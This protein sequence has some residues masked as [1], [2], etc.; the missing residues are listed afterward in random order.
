[1]NI[2]WEKINLGV[3]KCHKYNDPED[4]VI[5]M[6]LTYFQIEK[7]LDIGYGLQ[8][9][10]VFIKLWIIKILPSFDDIR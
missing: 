4:M 8:Y 3:L 10:K 2:L 6:N 7:L 5:T 1:M 9:L